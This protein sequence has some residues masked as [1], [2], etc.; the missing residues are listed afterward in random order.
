MQFNQFIHYARCDTYL[1]AKNGN[2]ELRY[3]LYQAAHV[4]ASRSDHF[5]AYF[6]KMLQAR[7]RE[8]G[9]KTKMKV[10]LAAKMLVIAWTLVKKKEVFDPDHLGI[11]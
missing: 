8:K 7:E 1:F 6:A 11:D 2:S 5:R 10:K 9:I 4:A 3:A